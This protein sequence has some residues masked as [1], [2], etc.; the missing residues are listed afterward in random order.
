[1]KNRQQTSK[2]EQYRLLAI[3]SLKERARANRSGHKLQTESRH[4]TW[5]QKKVSGP[6]I[7]ENAAKLI[8]LA[9]RDMLRS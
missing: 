2:E 5:I 6:G 8:A 4:Q 9:I 3:K 7:S 1:M